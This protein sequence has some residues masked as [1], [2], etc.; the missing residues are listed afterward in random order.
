[1]GTDALFSRT[2]KIVS[3]HGLWVGE[4]DH[5]VMIVGPDGELYIT[6]ITSLPVRVAPESGVNYRGWHIDGQDLFFIGGAGTKGRF[7]D[8]E[9]ERPEG[10][11]TSGDCYDDLL[12]LA[13]INS[14]ESVGYILR[15][16]N[17]K[18]TNYGLLGMIEHNLGVNN[19][20]GS[21]AA[22]VRVLTLTAENYGTVTDEFSGLDLVL[23]NE[24]A[25]ATL[26]FGMRLRNLNASLGTFITS[27]YV[28]GDSGANIGWGYPF[29]CNGATVQKADFRGSTGNSFKWAA[30]APSGTVAAL[31]GDIVYNTGGASGG[32]PGWQCTTAGTPGTWRALAVNASS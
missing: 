9:A 3:Q 17:G 12:K 22:T 15:A 5:E 1:V 23:K 4:Q 11:D 25:V 27:G 28:V 21:T 30:A 2:Q 8:I 10:A 14:S 26:E 31:Q 24:G 16:L 19:K 7:I 6:N 13:A 20:G 18:V 29:D 32:S